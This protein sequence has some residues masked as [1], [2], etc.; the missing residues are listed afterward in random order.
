MLRGR[1]PFKSPAKA[2]GR[3]ES[4]F[5]AG[6]EAIKLLNPSLSGKRDSRESVRLVE[7]NQV[8]GLQIMRWADN[9]TNVKT[10]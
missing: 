10:H 1:L 7:S 3:S 2:S 9:A 8:S 5:L 4:G 6:I